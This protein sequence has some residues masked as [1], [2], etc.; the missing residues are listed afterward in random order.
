ML[1]HN[2]L[3]NILGKCEYA[4]MVPLRRT[5]E[6]RS[7]LGTGTGDSNIKSLVLGEERLFN[8]VHGQN[9][10]DE[11]SASVKVVS[12]VGELDN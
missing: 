9:V 12:G 7:F 11:V 4:D 8:M 6:E 3:S 1:S 2:L 10:L 5:A